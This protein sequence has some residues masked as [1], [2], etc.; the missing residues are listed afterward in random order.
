MVGYFY[1]VSQYGSKQNEGLF[2][3]LSWSGCNRKIKFPSLLNKEKDRRDIAATGSMGEKC[4]SRFGRVAKH[5]NLLHFINI[6][7]DQQGA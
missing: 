3:P 5:K 4:W 1:K 2:E 6:L 7:N